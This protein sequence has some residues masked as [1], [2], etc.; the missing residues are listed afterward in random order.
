VYS[1]RASAQTR[2][3][4]GEFA[5]EP[6]SRFEPGQNYQ[7]IDDPAVEL[8]HLERIVQRRQHRRDPV[9]WVTQRLRGELW[10][11]QRQ[12]LELLAANRRLVV[13][14]CHA[15]GKSA[16]AARAICWW[17]DTLPPGKAFVV[18]TAPSVNQVKAILWR[19]IG[20][21]H[22][23]AKLRGRLNQTEWL[24]VLNGREEL[25]AFGRKP[26]EYDSD[27]FQGI[28]A[29]FV[30]VVVDEANGVRG[31]LWEAADSLIS[32]DQS[33]FLTIGNPD[34]PT[35]EF[36]QICQP[37]SGWVV[38]PI[39]AFDT[40]NFTGEECDPDIKEQL[41]GHV[42]VEERRRKW[43]SRWYWVDAA[44]N[45]VESYR[46]GV[47]CVPPVGESDTETQPLWQSK[48][49][50]RFPTQPEEMTLIPMAWVKRAQEKTLSV[51]G[52]PNE[53]GLDVGGGGDAS[54]I[55]HRRGG[56]VRI[57]RSDR[58][59]D[60][61]QTC[62]N[63]VDAL[64]RTGASLAKVDL[65]GI[66]RGVVDRAKELGRPV[67]GV[68][69]GE[70]ADDEESFVKRRAELWWQVRSMFERDE[71]DLD[72]ADDDLAAELGSIRFKRTSAAQVQVESK[73]DAYARVGGSPNRADALM[74]ALSNPKKKKVWEATW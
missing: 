57:I 70:G 64:R 46:D 56:R 54:V 12:V 14:S 30:L 68:N 65:V 55:A 40:P 43:A 69:V 3:G 13:P 71:V 18:T 25:V 58:N 9:A 8:E 22:A 53:L 67:E 41:I 19:E 35:G 37:G 42:Y 11:K 39:S 34:D 44:G 63:L 4:T 61:M 27:A 49:L 21:V 62:G 47:R 17:L 32:N 51:E 59:P 20:R 15:A 45:P 73:A 50:G 60:T 31:P 72:P 26:D 36:Y 38:C 23:A 5:P 48:V 2:T 74:L 52:M 10:S 66:G 33:K 7:N 29:P 24:D 1:A 16:I 6:R 28:H